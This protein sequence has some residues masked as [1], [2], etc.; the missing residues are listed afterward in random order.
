GQNISAEKQWRS[1]LIDGEMPLL[2]ALWLVGF[3]INAESQ[4]GRK[5]SGRSE[6]K[7]PEHMRDL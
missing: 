6:N 1:P 4:A 3:R 5:G 7:R 2:V